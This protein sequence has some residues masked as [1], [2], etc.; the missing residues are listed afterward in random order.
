MR[1]LSQ[2]INSSEILRELT[3]HTY[4]PL[5]AVL[6]PFNS[7]KS[8]LLNS[9]L[10]L[11]L[12]PVGVLPTTS[13]LIYFDYGSSF[14]ASVYNWHR[15]EVFFQPAELYSFLAK[16]NVSGGRVEIEIPTPIL[17]KCRLLDTPGIDSPDRESL[18][19]SGLAAKKADKIIY[20]FHQ[21]GIDKSSRLF[22]Y[23]LAL[24][25]KTKSLNDISF[26]LNCNLGISDGT[27]LET[28]R[29]ALREIFMS[30]VRIYTI[31]T[32]VRENIETL[33]LFLEMQLA[34]ENF[35]QAAGELRKI[36]AGIPRKLKKVA[37]IKDEALFLAEFWSIQQTI[38]T[39]LEA[40][41][42]IHT[43]PSFVQEMDHRLA[44]MNSVNLSANLMETEKKAGGTTYRPRTQ[45]IRE[46]RTALLGITRQLIND[47]VIKEYI[48]RLR[49]AQISG[50]IASERFTVTVAGGFS[51]GKSTFINTLLKDDILPAADGPTTSVITRI[52]HGTVKKATIHTPLQTTVQ[53][54][55]Q[56]G[57]K[58]VLNRTALEALER[59]ITVD[60]SGISLLEAFIDGSFKT[61]EPREMALLLK[62]TRELFAAGAFART[63]R[64]AQPSIYRRIPVKALQG[65]QAPQKI[66]VTFQDPGAREF[67][68]SEPATLQLF[69]D[70]MG[71]DCALKV[72]E[73]EIQHPSEFLEL[74]VLVDTPGLDWIQRHHHQ[75]TSFN[76]KNSDVCLVFLNGKHILSDIER[77]NFDSLFWLKDM[78]HVEKKELLKDNEKIFYVI[79][80]ADTLSLPQRE[81]V[82][83]YVMSFLKKSTFHAAGETKPKIFMFSGLKGLTGSE[84]GISSLLKSLEEVVLKYRGRNFYLNRLNDIYYILDAATQKIN[85]TLRSG[86]PAHG[87]KIMLRA[88]LQS[89][90]EYR[91]QIKNVRNIIYDTG[92][93]V[94]NGKRKTFRRAAEEDY[95]RGQHSDRR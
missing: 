83:N 65:G 58:A 59:W 61:V 28:S 92:R 20:L 32:L 38:R 62:R 26:W 63:T 35:R 93:F 36:D 42:L 75:N 68:I 56:V 11:Q 51:T 90:R 23:K 24:L 22:L 46:N 72:K 88:A 7:G 43:T 9:L 13:R 4:K 18:N 87:E 14:R 17:K 27:S 12:S 10:G 33:R 57:D 73:V 76:I 48:D 39:I 8:T 3:G 37:S 86:Q 54:Y 49:L 71:P 81:I 55:E 34:R 47:P 70:A 79:S 45:T 77:D 82:Y 66:R 94:I 25:W 19:V 41:R 64:T 53:V 29:S 50:L 6:G 67:D 95:T 84:S 91:S 16:D 80:F 21:R 60:G 5:L 31:N 15:K 78:E 30:P 52:M 74:A 1:D 85:S 40:G 2:F 44:A 69:W 89:L